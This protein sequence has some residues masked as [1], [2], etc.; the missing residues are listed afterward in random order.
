MGK[1]MSRADVAKMVRSAW[2]RTSF[3]SGITFYPASWRYSGS[4]KNAQTSSSGNCRVYVAFENVARELGI[5]VSDEQ[6]VLAGRDVSTQ[7]Q[8]VDAIV[9][10][11]NSPTL[12]DTLEA[13][14]N[15]NSPD[16][17]QCFTEELRRLAPDAVLRARVLEEEHRAYWRASHQLSK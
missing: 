15:P 11:I 5:D 12:A 10:I 13:A 4:D 1:K 2:K 6:F 7:R 14:T 8:A 9:G 16:F 17:D 3:T